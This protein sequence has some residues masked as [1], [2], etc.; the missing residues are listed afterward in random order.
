M[1]PEEAAEDA[2]QVTREVVRHWRSVADDVAVKLE[3]VGP[4]EGDQMVAAVRNYLSPW[5]TDNAPIDEATTLFLSGRVAAAQ[6][7]QI[8]DRKRLEFIAKHEAGHAVVGWALGVGIT[9]ISA[10]PKVGLKQDGAVHFDTTGARAFGAVSAED[11]AVIFLAG[12]A[13]LNV[14]GHENSW[15]GTQS[16]LGS[17]REIIL[18][19]R[20]HMTAREAEALLDFCEARADALVRRYWPAV[21]ALADL[22]LRAGKLRGLE[23]TT[24]IVRAMAPHQL[25][26]A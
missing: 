20:P 14:S 6:Y 17:A 12:H 22:L 21:D 8:K 2:R 19:A 26:A 10:T 18:F 5:L 13:A 15:S 3:T 11:R 9:S 24:T 1:T 7:A 25:A 4:T 23:A 16:D